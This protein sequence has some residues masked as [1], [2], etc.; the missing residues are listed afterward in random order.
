MVQKV[1]TRLIDDL[2]GS[3]AAETV[4]FALEG[5]EY[6]IDLSTR[7]ASRLRDGLAAFVSSARKASGARRSPARRASGRAAAD[8]EQAAAVREWARANGFEVSDRGRISA[9]VLE[10]YERRA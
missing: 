2:D 10:A 1:E 6:E 8:R 9:T 7:N 3:A 4:R 5:R